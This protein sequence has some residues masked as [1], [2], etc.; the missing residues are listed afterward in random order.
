MLKDSLEIVSRIE[1]F[2]Y[3]TYIVGGFVRD[4][5]INKES[6]DVD[7]CT[8]AK[9]KELIKIFKDAILPK[10][11]YGA[12]TLYYKNIRFE[13][14]T[15]RKELRYENRRPV[16]IEYSNN[17]FDD[18]TRRDFTINTLCMNS[19]GEIVDLFDGRKDIDKKVIRTVG[20]EN[21]K[22]SEDP[23][24]MLR[25]VRFSTQLEFLLDKSVI[26]AIQNNAYLLKDISYYRK[27]DELNKIFISSNA[28][29]GIKLLCMLKMDKYLDLNNLKNIK[30]VSDVLGI[31]AQ[32]A[33]ND[34]YPFSR[35]ELDTINSISEI[36]RNKRMS[37]YE[38][39]KYGL[40]N[41]TIAAEILGIN[42]KTVLKIDQNLPIHSK[43][44]ID[45]TTD[46]LCRLLNKKPDK[47]LKELYS[48]IEIQI[49][50]YKLKN[51]KDKI[52]EYI[53]KNY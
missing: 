38:L 31:W 51:S 36:V 37:A 50:S 13:I 39:Y 4:Y 46:E 23:L 19:K 16:E 53:V 47:W 29:Y 14:T 33:V 6:Y 35:L 48:D 9:P 17:F 40:Y 21:K 26:A 43:K 42:K 11:Q 49:L 2:G 44:D 32:L 8:S 1:S 20:D 7:I 5:Y 45:I 52:T 22:F 18:M 30:V 3:E 12:V 25:A 27:K 41:S 10:E 34:K 24:R 28:R 15:F